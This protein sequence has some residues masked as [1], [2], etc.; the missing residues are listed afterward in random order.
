MAWKVLSPRNS[1][2][3]NRLSHEQCRKFYK[4]NGEYSIMKIAAGHLSANSLMVRPV[5]N[6]VFNGLYPTFPIKCVCTWE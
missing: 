5:V 1:H 6:T 4:L 3:V 2:L